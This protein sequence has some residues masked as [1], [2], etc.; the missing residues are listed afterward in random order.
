MEMGL[1]TIP[2]L[3]W[4]QVFVDIQTRVGW[5]YLMLTK[6]TYFQVLEQF[7]EDFRT[8]YPKR[9]RPA[10][11]QSDT[12]LTFEGRLQGM[13]QTIRNDNAPELTSQQVDKLLRS[14][15]IRHLHTVPHDHIMNSYAERFILTVT[16]I[17]EAILANAK[18][19]DQERR[20][21]Y[22]RAVK[23]SADVYNLMRPHRGLG[24]R[25][26]YEAWTGY[27][28]N[29]NWLRIFG[30]T[31]YVYLELAERPNG[32]RSRPYVAGIYVGMD[33]ETVGTTPTHNI[34]IPSWDKVVNRRS[35]VFDE[36]LSHKEDRW[37]RLE[38]GEQFVLDNLPMDEELT[39]TNV[40]IDESPANA[41]VLMDEGAESTSVPMAKS[42]TETNQPRRSTRT[43]LGT[44][45]QRWTRSAIANVPMDENKII[46][47]KPAIDKGSNFYNDMAQE[48]RCRIK[49][50]SKIICMKPAIDEGTNLYNDMAQEKQCRIKKAS[51]II[52]M[53]PAIDEGTNLYNDMAQEKQCRIKKASK[54]ICMKPAIDEGT[55]LYNDMAQE[56]RCR[57]KKASKIICIKP[58]I[59]EGTNLYN[60]MAQEKRCRIKKA[61]VVFNKTHKEAWLRKAKAREFFNKTHKEARLR[62]AKTR[63]SQRHNTKMSDWDNPS[64]QWARTRNDWPQW[65]DAINKE[66]VQLE[67]RGTWK[68][69]LHN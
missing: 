19:T 11:H 51:K 13:I 31:A 32:K 18:F 65:L 48:K 42:P 22:C 30:C 8:K 58:A 17:V 21:I 23:H 35:V 69:Y 15:H 10:I 36:T 43:N 46:C 26:P 39:S 3:C 24:F 47:I 59:D 4:G 66:M 20:F 55:N 61:S 33:P 38:N 57:I 45:P 40:P 41:D 2:L 14:Q 7:L 6:G 67:A 12:I 25:T 1:D 50:A 68:V 64:L 49:K 60:D 16:K 52:C 63:E 9:G 28:P 5:V 37:L 27:R 29:A 44:P 56:K 53:K 54:I 62:K 34:Y